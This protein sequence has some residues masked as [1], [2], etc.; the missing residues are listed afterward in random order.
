MEVCKESKV[1]DIVIIYET[2]D[3]TCLV[4]YGN[5]LMRPG[6]GLNPTIPEK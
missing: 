2:C 3:I 6:V 1:S 5:H 4:H